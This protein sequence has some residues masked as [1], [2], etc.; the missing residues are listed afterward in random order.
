MNALPW[1]RLL[2]IV[3]AVALF[4]APVL[5]YFSPCWKAK[6]WCSTTS[7]NG[8]GG[9]GG[10]RAPRC[11]GRRSLVDRQHVQ[12]HAR[13]PDHGEVDGQPALVVDDAFHGFL[14]RPANFLFLYLLGMYVLLRIL[15][16]DPWL[17]VVGAIA[18]AFSSYFFVILP[19]GHTSKANAIGY[20]PLVFGAMYLL[21][22]GDK[23]TGASLLALFLGL[24]VMMNHVQITY[25]LAMLLGLFGLAEGARAFREKA[26]PDF[27]LRSGLGAVAVAL[28][29]V[30]NMGMLWS[31]VEYGKYSTRG[32][33]RAHHPARWLER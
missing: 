20:M 6:G 29:L 21:F 8:R 26:L 27:A 25:Y 31:T 10:E 23:W 4:Y 9:P 16:V 2:P 24:E 32:Q 12:R 11:H 28:A 14:P 3:A 33:E 7:S 22:R 13:V 17:S 15:K 18:F 19:A 30:C 5:A 1:K